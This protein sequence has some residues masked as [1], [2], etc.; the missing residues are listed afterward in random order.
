MLISAFYPGL[1]NRQVMKGVF[2]MKILENFFKIVMGDHTVLGSFD[3]MVAL[4]IAVL[5]YII[6]LYICFAAFSFAAWVVL[7]VVAFKAAFEVAKPGRLYMEQRKMVKR[8]CTEY[9]LKTVG[10]FLLFG[11]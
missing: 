11:D 3:P 8:L 10:C 5:C 2:I 1:V 6:A 7:Q 4:S 9:H